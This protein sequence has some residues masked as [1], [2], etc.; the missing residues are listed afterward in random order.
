MPYHITEK[1][2]FFLFFCRVYFHN[3][4]D[5]SWFIDGTVLTVMTGRDETG[6][7]GKTVVKME[8]WSRPVPSTISP[9]VY[10]Y[11][12]VSSSFISRCTYRPVPSRK[13]SLTVPRRRP[14]LP[15]PSRL[16][17]KT[18]PYRPAPSSK[19]AD[20]VPSRNQDLSLP[21]NPAVKTCCY[22]A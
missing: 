5:S 16:V 21:S 19:P 12:P 10:S 20:T 6:R 4:Q 2:A 13:Y 11:R 17:Y 22:K 3:F 9:T 18:Y 15:L 1:H 14:N 8:P 7:D